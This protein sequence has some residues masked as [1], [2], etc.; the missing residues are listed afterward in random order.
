MTRRDSV[1]LRRNAEQARKEAERI[2]QELQRQTEAART[3]E[4][5]T[6]MQSQI[7]RN[8]LMGLSVGC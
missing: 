6:W 4:V 8:E 5:L 1:Q 3:T 7:R 2:R